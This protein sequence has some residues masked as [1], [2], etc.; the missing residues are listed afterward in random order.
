MNPHHSLSEL[1]GRYTDNGITVVVEIFR[2]SGADDWRM[3]V[4]DTARRQ[5]RSLPIALTCEHVCSIAL[6]APPAFA[7]PQKPR[8]RPPKNQFALASTSA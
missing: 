2:P 5:L 4:T 3:V 1:S 7:P 6:I 8:G